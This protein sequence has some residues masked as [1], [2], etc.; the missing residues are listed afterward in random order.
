M[1]GVEGQATENRGEFRAVL[2]EMVKCLRSELN[3]PGVA[4]FNPE[5]LREWFQNITAEDIRSV[6]DEGAEK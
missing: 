4:P 2:R 1:D 3:I 5:D 6:W